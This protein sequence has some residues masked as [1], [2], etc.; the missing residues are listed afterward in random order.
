[1]CQFGENFKAGQITTI[2]PVCSNHEDS[3]EKSFE[4]VKLKEI[5]NVRGNYYQEIFGK[6]FPSELIKT[7]CN[8][9][10]YREERKKL[11]NEK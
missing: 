5:I 11:T 8:V 7:L 3:Q 4:C 10:F 2:C 6:Q 1:M 9:Q